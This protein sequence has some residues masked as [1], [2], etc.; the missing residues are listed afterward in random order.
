MIQ[1]NLQL[2]CDKI[3]AELNNLSYAD[4]SQDLSHG[5]F[6]QETEI[7]AVVAK[8]CKHVDAT[9]RTRIYDE[10]F[11][12]GPLESLLEDRSLTEILVNGPHSI[13]FETAGQLQ[14]W[15]D[16][17]LTEITFRNFIQRVCRSAHVLPTL[18]CPF[19]DGHWQGFR[20]HLMIPP[21]VKDATLTLR[22]HPDNPWTLQQ[23]KDMKWADELAIQSLRSLVRDKK[24]FLVVGC[25]GS[26][27]TSVLNACL[28]EMPANERA[29]LIEDTS[30]L[31]VPNVLSTKLLTRKDSNQILREIDQSE[32]L[33]QSLRMRPDRIIMG[34]IRG[35]EAKDLL[36]AFAT[37][38]SGCMG[39]LHADSARQALLRLEM[40]IQ[41]GAAQ[42]SLQAVRTLILLS[43]QYVVVVKRAV[44]GRRVLD[45]IY[46]ITSLEDLGFLLEKTA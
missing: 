14:Q 8:Y 38:H 42:W 6:E 33:K 24:N 20:L 40:L 10:Y 32:L 5:T 25:T 19:A 26:G 22:R 13:W 45:G 36:M 35:A 23:F 39:T 1:E 29:I 7:K 34:E 11:G 17:F 15:H 12:S 3:A 4:P 37:G 9:T 41:M 2:I 43:L 21:A 28:Q 27:K 16:C 46:R 44:D 30:E 31:K 18:D